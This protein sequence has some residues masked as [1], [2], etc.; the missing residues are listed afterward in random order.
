MFY[1]KVFCSTSE[2]ECFYLNTTWNKK[3]LS[4]TYS[5]K[6]LEK[7]AWALWKIFNLDNWAATK[8]ISLCPHGT[9]ASSTLIFSKHF[10]NCPGIFLSNSRSLF[11]EQT[12]FNHKLHF[13]CL[14]ALIL[15]NSGWT[16]KRTK[17]RKFNYFQNFQF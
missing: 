17:V 6:F 4:E 11:D 5:L 3:L 16:V 15:Q 9:P 10:L 8:T 1:G 7:K 14:A 13:A 12:T 2:M